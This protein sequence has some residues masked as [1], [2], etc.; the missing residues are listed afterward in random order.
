MPQT[1]Q[2]TVTN[3]DGQQVMAS[4][5]FSTVNPAPVVSSFT[6]MSGPPAGGGTMTI[7]GANFLAGARVF[8]GSVEA[9]V[10]SVT[11]GQITLTIPALA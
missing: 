11:P 5:T 4:G 10:A 1:Y 3:P 9:V 8:F 2:I 6:P 7:S